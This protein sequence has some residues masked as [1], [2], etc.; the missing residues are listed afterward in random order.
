MNSLITFKD[1]QEEKISKEVQ[2]EMNKDS[3]NLSIYAFT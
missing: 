3:V 1:G 2:K